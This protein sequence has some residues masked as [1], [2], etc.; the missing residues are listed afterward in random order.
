MAGCRPDSTTVRRRATPLAG[1][2]AALLVA[3][4]LAGC[5]GPQLQVELPA[6]WGDTRED[7]S[8]TLRPDGT[9]YVENFPSPPAGACSLAASPRFSGEVEW[10]PVAD[11][12][13]IIPLEH[14]E[15][16]V[17]ADIQAASLNWSKL[18]VAVRGEDTP[19]SDEF[20]LGG[21]ANA[22]W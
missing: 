14:G 22:D 9:A 5:S 18:V 13:F 17:G 16:L 12:R 15:V 6:T 7:V 8:L 2:V 1:S 10:Q 11:G 20:I 3:S 4:V 19:R 21:G